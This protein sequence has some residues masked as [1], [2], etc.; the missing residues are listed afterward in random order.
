MRI[1]NKCHINKKDNEFYIHKR[2]E[3]KRTYTC[4]VCQKEIQRLN[5]KTE[6]S[7]KLREKLN[8][9]RRKSDYYKIQYARFG[10]SYKLKK[11]FGITEQDYKIM[12]NK[13][14][15]V[16]AICGQAETK[17]VSCSENKK[18]IRPLSIDHDHKTGRVRAL[19]CDECNNGIARFKEN[20]MYLANAISYLEKHKAGELMDAVTGA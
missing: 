11:A 8:Q 3:T 18:R 16:C 1:C 5:Y 2:G 19:L 14:K 10:R 9:K 17:F 20:T 12:L 6:H 4:I 15:G 7:K 13:Q